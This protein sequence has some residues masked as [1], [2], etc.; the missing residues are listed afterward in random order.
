[1]KLIAYLLISTALRM[2][3]EKEKRKVLQPMVAERIDFD[4]LRI[5]VRSR[6]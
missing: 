5:N 1:V 3:Y 2:W 6:A 4:Q